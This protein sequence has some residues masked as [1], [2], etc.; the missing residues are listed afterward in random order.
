VALI[1]TTLQ[2]TTMGRREPGDVVNLEVDVLAKYVERLA[3][4]H[5]ARL[6]VQE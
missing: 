5:L 1:P 2:L 3:A 6:G 4:G